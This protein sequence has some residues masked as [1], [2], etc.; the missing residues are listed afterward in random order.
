[1]YCKATMRPRSSSLASRVWHAWTLDLPGSYY[2]QVFEDL[3]R[4]NKLARGEFQALGRP[5]DL[6]N[7]RAPL[8]LIASAQDE[9]TPSEQLMAV[10]RLVGTRRSQISTAMARGSHLSLFMGARNS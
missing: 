10:E 5:V 4:R 3:F 9:V 2:L 6:S 8:F 7:I 1:M